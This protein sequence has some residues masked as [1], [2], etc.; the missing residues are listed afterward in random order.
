MR[1]PI[2]A[3][4]L[5]QTAPSSV[6]AVPQQITFTIGHLTRDAD[7]VAVEVVVFLAAFAIF[8]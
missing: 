1:V 7:L 3:F 2:D 5:F 4:I 8:G 6:F